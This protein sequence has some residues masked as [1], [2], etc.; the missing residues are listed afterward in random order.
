FII[1]W[2]QL[3]TNFLPIAPLSQNSIAFNGNLITYYKST[4]RIEAVM[5]EPGNEPVWHSLNIAGL[6][7]T[8]DLSTA[9]VNDGTIFMLDPAGYT[10]YHST[11]GIAWNSVPG[12]H[13]IGA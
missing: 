9:T 2:Q 4:E 5:T 3:H 7:S 11:D 1:N 10:L 12:S 6:P 13:K 8:T